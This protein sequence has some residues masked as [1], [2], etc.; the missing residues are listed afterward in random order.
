MGD[1]ETGEKYAKHLDVS[2]PDY[3]TEFNIYFR[4]MLFQKLLVHTSHGIR[5]VPE[6]YSVP[7]DS[8]DSELASPGSQEFE[9][10]GRIPFMWAQSLYVIS[11]LL[12]DSFIACGELDPINRRLSSLKRPEV[13]VQ[14]VV[15]AKDDKIKELLQ[16][17]GYNCKTLKEVSNIEVHPARVLSHLYTFLGRSD[18]LQLSGRHS[19]DVGILTTS[20]LYKVQGKVFAF[21]PQR[22]DF[23]RNYMDCDP[24]LMMTTLEYGL[25]YLSKCWT[26]SGR[27]TISLV[28]GNNML[29]NGK[30]PPALL[31]ALKKLRAGYINGTRV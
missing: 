20:K 7:L 12:K 21:T 15:L 22:F 24:N 13:V 10:S 18:K 16:Q 29:E 5:L 19:R 31:S 1:I 27:P 30:M 3:A 8:I 9:A 28:M 14:V 2:Q 11:Q 25:Y 6:L 4:M 26:T 17:A 23:E